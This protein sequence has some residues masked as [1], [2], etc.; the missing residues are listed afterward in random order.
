MFL[1]IQVDARQLDEEKI[2]DEFNL[3]VLTNNKVSDVVTANFE[4]KDSS[5]TPLSDSL[6]LIQGITD[7][8]FSKQLLTDS[9]GKASTTLEKNQIFVYTIYKF[10]YDPS[11]N[12]FFTN[13]DKNIQVALNKIPSNKWYFYYIN[14]GDIEV[15]F[16]SLD[17]DTNYN[18]NEYVNNILEIR[19]VAGININLIRD[20]TSF[21][22]VDAA[23]LRE[24]RWWG[25]LKPHEILV[26]LTL[27]KDGWLKATVKDDIL[28]VC[29]GNTIGNY[30]GQPFDVSGSEFIC[31]TEDNHGKLGT[32]LI[33]E[34][35]L[36]N[37]Y[38]LAI[39][40]TYKINNQE[41]LFGLL[42]QEFFIDNI[43]WKPE[44]NSQP[45]TKVNINQDWSYDITPKYPLYFVYYSLQ[46]A[47]TGMN[48]DGEKGA[49][50]WKPTKAGF[51]DIIVRAEYPYF[52]DDYK[53]T[54]KDQAFT[55][56]VFEKGNL[57]AD[58]LYI[59][60]RNPKIGENVQVSFVVYNNYYKK[61]SFSYKVLVDSNNFI[62]YKIN[63]IKP[64]EKRTIYTSWKYNNAGTF[65]PI[66][67][68]D[69][70]NEIDEN[71]ENDNSIS[72]PSL[73]VTQ[74]SLGKKMISKISSKKIFRFGRR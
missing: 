69:S 21:K 12:N 64:Y 74:T 51:Y 32:N 18:T 53:I 24:L 3:D 66:L 4:V 13:S 72:F 58:R 50:T 9:N 34:W 29:A 20:K 49:I 31:K 57:Y 39:D 56:E 45:Q 60:N 28:E 65:T 11:T 48:I 36:K 40:I 54:Y 19:N 67:I 8:T 46:K 70:N 42:T 27:K 59:T 55:L 38:K 35:I 68:I 6:I 26:D 22:T 62:T 14:N 61:N 2:L 16:K 30:R 52:Y 15:K 25:S 1:L 17:A 71:N 63:D 7:Q 41:K 43:E 37:T 10:T 44:I 23:T 5:G 33:P 73:T 47:P